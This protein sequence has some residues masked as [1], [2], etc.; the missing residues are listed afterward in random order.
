VQESEKQS[1]TGNVALEKKRQEIIHRVPGTVASAAIACASIFSFFIQRHESLSG[2]KTNRNFYSIPWRGHTSP[3]PLR[4]V[5]GRPWSGE[6]DRA[7]LAGVPEGSPLG[8]PMQSPW[9]PGAHNDVLCLHEPTA[10][11]R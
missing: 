5:M 2:M 6:A 4:S 7:I 1:A 10:R 3:Y 11:A 8:L 9:L